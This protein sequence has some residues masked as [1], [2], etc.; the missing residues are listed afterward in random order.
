MVNLILHISNQG[1]TAYE[2]DGRALRETGG[3]QADD[4]G[5]EAF[6][7][8]LN[9]VGRIPVHIV[10]D[11]IEEEFRVES[12][13]HVLG[14][15]RTALHQRHASR[16]FRSS[17]F[18][19]SRVLD[20]QKEKRRDDN[21]LFSALGN[22]EC[23][24]HWLEHLSARAMPL[25]GIHSV[26]MLS[27][28]LVK[29]LGFAK[30][31]VLLLT[32]NRNGGLRQSYL[33][34]GQVRFSRLR[35]V[36]DVSSGDY[37]EYIR[38]EINKTRRYLGSLHFIGPD[39]KLDVCII[40]GGAY[41]A[42]L[43]CLTKER[44]SSHYHL[45]EVA[46]VAERVGRNIDA[47]E[48]FCDRLFVSLLDKARCKNIYAQARHRQHFQ[49]YRLRQGLQAS[50]MAL[51][52]G[53]LLWSGVNVSDGLIFREQGLQ[54][55]RLAQQA[56]ARYD[57]VASRLPAVPVDAE[58]IAAAVRVADFIRDQRGRPGPLLMHISHGLGQF[59][60]L[61]LHEI[62]WRSDAGV[63]AGQE[64]RQ[65]ALDP[66][67]GVMPFGDEDAS[68][69]PYQYAIIKGEIESFDGNYLRAHQNIESFAGV[70]RRQPDIAEV[71]ILSLPLNVSQEAT[72]EGYFG[73]QQRPDNAKF[74]VS[75]RM[76]RSHEKVL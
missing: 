28:K 23:L 34:R 62:A 2:R 24:N 33:Q 39:E 27:E 46:L 68:R 56:Q 75:I 44:L 41:L 17:D 66:Q 31:K 5:M 14:R 10:T 69:A 40:S 12:L 29:Q 50:T 67:G 15:D 58:D 18:R 30:T 59:A 11:F 51:A 72:V 42:G 60:D 4:A 49:T 19:Y 76:R 13:P 64:A 45:N 55:A 57:A 48:A 74:T 43:D 6:A 61:R 38:E 9:T 22:P 1:V 36:L 47:G 35:P 54:S 20:R 3:F 65:E 52:A 37:A 63:S 7:A 73:K 26:A 16:L 53:A 21:V 71:E 32:H 8:Y 70:L 25:A